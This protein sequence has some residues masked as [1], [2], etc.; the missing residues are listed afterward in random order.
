MEN[1]M[2]TLYARIISLNFDEQP[3]EQI[4]GRVT[5]GSVNIDGNSAV[6]RT[7][8]L[9]LISETPL[10]DY[11]WTLNTKFKLAIGVENNIDSRYPNIIWFE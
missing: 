2:R 6:R 10:T 3:L 5:S 11:F 8:S 1:K 4:E 9:S 7:C